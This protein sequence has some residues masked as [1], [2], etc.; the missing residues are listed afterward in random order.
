MELYK[1]IGETII[2]N[3]RIASIVRFDDSKEEIRIYAKLGEETIIIT[4]EVE[5]YQVDKIIEANAIYESFMQEVC[6]QL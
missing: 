5:L 4:E 1:L 3:G 2:H 6:A